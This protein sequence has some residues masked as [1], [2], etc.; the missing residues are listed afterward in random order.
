MMTL[1]IVSTEENQTTELHGTIQESGSKAD[2]Y[3]DLARQSHLQF[4][5]DIYRERN[6]TNILDYVKYAEPD[7]ESTLH[8]GISQYLSS[9][10][11][12]E[13]YQVKALI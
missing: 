12:S 3:D 4:P 7:P 6:D 2:K 13:S 11:Y 5:N 10:V 1:K 8:T 9:S